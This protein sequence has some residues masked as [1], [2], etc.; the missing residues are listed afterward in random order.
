MR[1]P[2]AAIAN[3]AALAILIGL[4]TLA[5]VMVLILG[6]FGLILLGLATLFVCTSI[7]LRD[8][9]PAWG[10]EVFKGR[11]GGLKTPEQRAAE[12]AEKEQTLAPLRFYRWC[13]IALVVAGSAGFAWQQL[14]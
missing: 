13:G 4:T 11:I 1:L 6:P 5:F 12:A 9:N 14:R 2:L 8:D 3:A 10:T 7:S